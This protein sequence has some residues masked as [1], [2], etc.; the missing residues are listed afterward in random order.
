[1][2][3]QGYSSKKGSGDYLREMGNA[4]MT[5]VSFNTIACRKHNTWEKSLDVSLH[6]HPITPL[7]ITD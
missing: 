1:M 3:Y 7:S 5:G 6:S 4:C 2:Y